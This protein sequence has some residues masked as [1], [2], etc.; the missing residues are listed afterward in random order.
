MRNIVLVII[1]LTAQAQSVAAQDA[2]RPV[3]PPV[4]LIAE[5]EL[6]PETTW[7]SCNCSNIAPA[8]NGRRL[9]I[10][11]DAAELWLYDVAAKRSTKIATDVA[12]AQTSVSARGNRLA[13]MRS[14]D[15]GS[16]G[17]A[18]WTMPLDPGTGLAAGP[19]RRASVGN[20]MYPSLSP[21]GAWIAFES[22]SGRR[23]LAVIPSE[24]GS[25]R[26]L[27]DEIE[28]VDYI[29][30]SPDQQ[31]LY[32]SAR[33]PGSMPNVYLPM[34]IAV[35]G[36]KPEM[37]A[38]GQFPFVDGE[39]GLSPDG[40]FLALGV[41][42]SASGALVLALMHVSG[43]P[44]AMLPWA[45]AW[46]SSSELLLWG[47][48]H[49]KPLK[50]IALVD[51][52][53]REVLPAAY[54]IGTA[55]WAPDGR[56]FAVLSQGQ[57]G[58][59]H[60]DSSRLLI[61]NADGS[62]LRTIAVRASIPFSRSSASRLVWSPDGRRIAM[63][64]RPWLGAQNALFGLGITAVDV[65]SGR[66]QRLRTAVSQ[67]IANLRWT[68]DSKHV[69]Y[70]YSPSDRPSG[71]RTR[72]FRPVIRRVGLDGSDVVVRTLPRA[73]RAE[74]SGGS[75]LAFISDTS[76]LVSDNSGTYVRSLT[77]DRFV[78]AWSGSGTPSASPRGE[79]VAMTPRGAVPADTSDRARRTTEI[80]TSAG[81]HV[82]TL[83]FPSDL[84]ADVSG[85]FLFTPDGKSLL[86]WGRNQVG[87]GCCKLYLAPLDGG[88]VRTLAELPNQGIPGFA[89]SPDGKTLLITPSGPTKGILALWAVDLSGLLRGGFLDQVLPE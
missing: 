85:S 87:E 77:S 16:A 73:E 80:L 56:R 50:S 31:W 81:V 71:G 4:R 89:L 15:D 28:Q 21:D 8:L 3:F 84:L 25:E 49:P 29:K 55:V 22:L 48:Y 88:P 23:H 70:D 72:I 69:L 53:V 1:A 57:R 37:I 63:T 27:L 9:Y 82:A 39:V 24:G 76:V 67:D 60:P 79:L 34:R 45:D 30:W 2:I 62:S 64:E 12:I 52:T 40:K 20:G 17:R 33:L 66:A 68:S 36:G 75:G 74:R 51:G 46:L 5:L 6:L 47:R 61:A 83:Q 19:A 78:R 43:K 32:F 10:G 42:A 26:V 86:A 13:F 58:A 38:D 14:A 44:I 65:A 7:R 11:T 18:I 59:S 54:D 41:R 35:V